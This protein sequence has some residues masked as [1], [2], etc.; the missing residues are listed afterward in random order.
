MNGCD[1]SAIRAGSVTVTPL[2]F[3]SWE[4]LPGMQYYVH[5]ASKPTRASH[6]RVRFTS[7]KPSWMLLFI[8]QPLPGLSAPRL[9]P[10]YSRVTI[11]TMH[12]NSVS[13][14]YPQ[15]YAPDLHSDAD[16]GLPAARFFYTLFPQVCRSVVGCTRNNILRLGRWI[17]SI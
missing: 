16:V 9:P 5:P 12:P 2:K 11:W 17:L 3:L 4:P 15:K 14:A 7:H 13:S 1:I 10:P 8:I 6:G